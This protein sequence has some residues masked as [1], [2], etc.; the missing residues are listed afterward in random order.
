MQFP[1]QPNG[2]LVHPGHHNHGQR[3]GGRET[4]TSRKD[5]PQEKDRERKRGKARAKQRKDQ[6]A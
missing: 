2:R 5:L 4:L 6:V 3:H 1:R